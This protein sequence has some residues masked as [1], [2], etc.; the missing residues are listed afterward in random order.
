MQK[1]PACDIAV[2]GARKRCPLC[3]RV[4]GDAPEGGES[5]GVFPLVPVKRTYDLIFRISTFAAILILAVVNIIHNLWLP[6]MPI[7]MTLTL[8]TVC[9]W[10]IVNVG[11]RK[12]KN[13]AK[14]ILWEGVIAVLLCLLWD[15]LNGWYGWSWGYVLTTVP[16]VLAVFY[17][18]M[19]IADS[20]RMGTYAAYF[21]V[22]LIGTAAVAVLYFTG[23]MTGLYRH[24]AVISMSVSGLLLAAQVVFRGKH[25]LSELER[26]MHV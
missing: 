11:A 14:G 20:R 10:I 2:D 3:G 25:F 26:W 18:I 7:Y 4:M 23:K 1:C 19:G 24:F 12:R 5:T 17:F 15:R 9:A 16:A 8:A 22:T 6:H 13:I 21:A